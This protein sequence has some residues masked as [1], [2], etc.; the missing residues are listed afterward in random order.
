MSR[1][2]YQVIKCYLTKQSAF[3]GAPTNDE[4][5]V[6][7]GTWLSALSILSNV[8]R[9]RWLIK[10]I[11]GPGLSRFGCPQLI[12]LST[13]ELF[14]TRRWIPGS[15][16]QSNMY[17][18]LPYMCCI[19]F[20]WFVTNTTAYHLGLHSLHLLKSSLF[21]PFSSWHNWRSVL[22]IKLSLLAWQSCCRLSD[23][24]TTKKTLSVQEREY[25]PSL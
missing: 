11:V 4:T 5:S 1:L 3:L 13:M 25:S 19:L 20:F 15:A 17:G 8:F 2:V 14:S 9:L 21:Q 24:F 16:Q 6:W 23:L 22:R 18:M 12:I 7:A 10:R